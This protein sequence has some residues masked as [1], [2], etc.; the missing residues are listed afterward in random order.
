MLFIFSDLRQGSPTSGLWTST[1]C[2]I[3]SSVRL[4]IQCTVGVMCL[5]HPEIITLILVRGKIVCHEISPWCQKGL[6]PLF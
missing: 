2:Q 4:E 6:G 3:S 5:N 1:S